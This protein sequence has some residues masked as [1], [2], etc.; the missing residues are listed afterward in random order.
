MYREG[1]S[2]GAGAGNGEIWG[3]KERE[4]RKINPKFLA[5][6]TMWARVV[7]PCNNKHW[8]MTKC[9]AQSMS[10]TLDNTVL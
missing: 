7:F 3:S 4:R 5:C 10:L 8:Q 1:N 9:G 6:I 2:L